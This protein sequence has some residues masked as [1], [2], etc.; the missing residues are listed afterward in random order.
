MCMNVVECRSVDL[1]ETQDFQG[2]K[3]ASLRSPRQ[4]LGE[5]KTNKNPPL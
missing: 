1:V 5:A 3:L 4:L 2:M